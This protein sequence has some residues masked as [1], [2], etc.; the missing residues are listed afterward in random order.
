MTAVKREKLLECEENEQ[1]EGKLITKPM[2]EMNRGIKPMQNFHKTKVFLM[3]LR[4]EITEP[5][6]V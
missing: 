4:T 2:T 6:R 5:M 1:E 3:L